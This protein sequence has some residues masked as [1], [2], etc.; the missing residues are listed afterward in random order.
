MNPKSITNSLSRRKFIAGSVASAGLFAIPRSLSGQSRT[1]RSPNDRLNLA[2]VGVGGKGMSSI[3]PLAEENLIGFCDVDDRSVERALSSKDGNSVFKDTIEKANAMGAKWYKDYRVMF[4]ELGDKLDGVVI[5]TP[6]HMHYPITQSALNLGLHVYC[7]KPLTHTVQ[8]ARWIS[9]K[10]KEMKVVTQMG[11]QG[12]SN[13]GTRLVRE[14]IQAG[15]IGPVREVHSWTNRP[16]WPQGIPGPDHSAAIPVVPQGLD[17][18]L[19]QGVAER[20]AYDPAYLPFKWRGYWDFGCGAVGDM[21]CH[22]MDAAYWAL[23]LAQPTRIEATTTGLNAATMPDAG[24]VRYEFPARGSFEPLTYY[25]YEGGMRPPVPVGLDRDK[26]LRRSN[27][28]LIIGER[29]TLLTDTYNAQVQI[30]PPEKFE[31]LKPLLP[32][33]TIPR[34]KG[35]HQKNWTDA[36]REGEMAVSDFEYAAQLTETAL[37]GNVAMRAARPLEY[38]AKAMAFTNAPD[39][40]QYLTK[41]Y[42]KGWIVG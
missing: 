5:S 26:I 9:A 22:I 38:D 31:E 32:P 8:E 11:N 40:N 30:V 27:G 16:I 28:T 39:A 2:F 18:D 20:R 34:V 3:V 36:I 7:E 24:V 14:W 23:D 41:E 6:D 21:A 35:T 15:V 1:S 10:A 29:A 12:H 19:W 37:L 4:E 17:W 13:S 42:R 33:K 25:W